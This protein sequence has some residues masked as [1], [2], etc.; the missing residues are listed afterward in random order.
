[1]AVSEERSDAGFTLVEVLAA[2]ALLSLLSLTL[3]GALRFG[4]AA[5]ERAETHAERVDNVV[6]AQNFLRRLIEDAYPFFSAADPTRGEIDFEGTA[7]GLRL[8]APTPQALGGS[9][10]SRVSLSIERREERLDLVVAVRPELA[11]DTGTAT[12]RVLVGD[13][14]SVELSYFGK[15]RSERAPGWRNQWTKEQALPQ[16]VR[17]EVQFP[18]GDKRTWPELVA[19]PRISVD[20]GC[21]YDP[22][23]K[24]CRGRQGR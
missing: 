12:R 23:N 9:G 16:L 21:V 13:V 6:L 17:I 14:Q 2:L 22:L 18:A 4:L 3:I 10:R 20:V 19:G 24:Q 7:V 8:L 1:M 5:W 11:G 15:G